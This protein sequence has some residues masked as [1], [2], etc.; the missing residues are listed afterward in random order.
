[1]FC[2]SN[3]YPQYFSMTV[4]NWSGSLNDTVVFHAVEFIS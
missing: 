4:N 3:E 2:A 1:M